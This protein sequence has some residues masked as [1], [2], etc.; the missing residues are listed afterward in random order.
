M[1][2]YG[3]DADHVIRHYDVN[4]KCCP[5]IIGWNK[6]TGDESKWEAF[7]AAILSRRVKKL[8]WIV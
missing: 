1:E 3:I 7:H 8:G 4:G 6:D 2:L 5:G